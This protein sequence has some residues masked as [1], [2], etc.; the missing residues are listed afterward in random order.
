MVRPG[1]VAHADWGT[2]TKKRQVAVAE[3]SESGT[4]RVIALAPARAVAAADG[5][6]RRGLGIPETASAQVLV[7]FDLPIGVPRAYA[8]RAGLESFLGLLPRIG[9]DSWT[10]FALVAERP[11]EISLQRPFYPARPGGTSRAQL[12]EGLALTREQL[13]RRSDGTDAETMFWTLG[14]KQVGKAALSGWE[15]LRQVSVEELRYWPFQG[16]L[17]TLLDGAP[18]TA[19]VTETYPREYYQ[20]FRATPFTGSKR[21][22]DDRL[23]WIPDLLEGA[24]RL[25]VTRQP[26]VLARVERGFSADGNGEDEFDAV[27]GLLGMLAVVTSVLPS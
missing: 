14:G 18:G 2:A 9:A 6:L 21:K 8:D 5:S 13:R 3:R 20:Y 17:E 24:G 16:S 4:Y 15:Y 25:G 10:Q 1:H 7:G 11:E 27:V 26:D 19:V 22:R 23:R 12:Y